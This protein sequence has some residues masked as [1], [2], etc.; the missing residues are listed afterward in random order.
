MA[1]EG[2]SIFTI[3]AAFKLECQRPVGMVNTMCE[4]VYVCTIDI[5]K[6]GSV[7]LKLVN[8]TLYFLI[9]ILKLWE[10]IIAIRGL[11]HIKKMAL[12]KRCS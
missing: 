1:D 8:G 12:R 4:C 2:L 11:D 7:S 3:I 10:L 5:T 9:Q 6:N